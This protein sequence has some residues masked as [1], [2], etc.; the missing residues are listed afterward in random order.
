VSVLRISDFSGGLN[1]RDSPNE[2]AASET[3]DAF[4]FTLDERGALKWRKG[5]VTAV[6][7]PGVAGK[8]CDLFYSQ[9]LGLWLCCRETA[10]APNTFRLHTHPADLSSGSWTDRG[11]IASGV[12]AQACFADWP[13]TTPFCL[14]G[15]DVVDVNFGGYYTLDATPT[16]TRRFGNSTVID[17]A[18]WQNKVWLI[19]PSLG[20]TRIYR[21]LVGDPVTTPTDFN[22]LREKDAGPLTALGVSGAGLLAYKMRSTYRITD[23]ATGAYV[24]IDNS[25]GC[26]HPLSLVAHHGRLYSWG[27]D[28]FYEWDGIG[29]GRN[30]GDKCRSLFVTPALASGPPILGVSGDSII[31]AFAADYGTVRDD[32]LEF[33]PAQKW[34]MRHSLASTTSDQISSFATK[35][36]T[37]YAASEDGNVVLKMFTE[38]PG[39]DDGVV[40]FTRYTTP[41]LQPTN[42]ALA[43]LQRAR[44]Q[45]LVGTGTSTALNFEV[46]K[47]WDRSTF[48]F[49]SI[50]TQLRGGDALD[51]QKST[52]L[53]AL[54][55]ARA[56]QF[57]FTPFTA[58]GDVK[59][60]GLHLKTQELER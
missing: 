2:L 5:C 60:T 1:L 34:I 21:S 53:Q 50:A 56:F 7:L 13:G 20:P 32:L 57:R 15:T 51:D 44:I 40:P 23:A 48:D 49:Y 35:D 8:T 54:G 38:T 43:R 14:I 31:G 9:A 33:N 59:I 28:A 47:D 22:D 25:A 27:A 11:Q 58:A 55:H 16:L 46:Y 42:G 39:S 24:L 12:G 29:A 6:A 26:L 3:P 36:N 17:L 30:V 41:W 37:L 18:I 4:N 19:V 45:G 10:G 52:D